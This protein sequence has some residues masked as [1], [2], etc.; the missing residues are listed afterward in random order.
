LLKNLKA[1]LDTLAEKSPE[2]LG[3]CEKVLKSRRYGGNVVLMVVDSAI[4][5][6]GVNYFSVVVPRVLSFKEKFIDSEK[7]TSLEDLLK[8]D[9]HE[10]YAIWKNKRS[11][12]VARGISETL[13]DH[14]DGI[15]ALR[16]WAKKSRPEKWREYLDVKGAGINTFQYLRMMGGID[17]VMP[18]RVVR[19]FL[20]KHVNMPD[21][22]IDFIRE[23]EK[24]SK[25]IG[26]RAVELCWLAWLSGYNDEKIRIYSSLLGKI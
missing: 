3:F 20:T 26:Y 25:K 16:R 24:L 17:T 10:F 13:L 9:L 22:E 6:V 2:T 15:K 11:W 8:L 23:A 5:S 7:V 1:E 4:T 14:G 18:D 19:K 21:N 12:I